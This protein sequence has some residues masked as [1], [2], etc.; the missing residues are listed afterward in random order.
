MGVVRHFSSIRL[1]E[2]GI[3]MK[4]I[5]VS[6]KDVELRALLRIMEGQKIGSLHRVV[7]IAIEEYIKRFE[8]SLT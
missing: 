6:L 8:E 3:S 7:K 5:T 2:I 1:I 4:M